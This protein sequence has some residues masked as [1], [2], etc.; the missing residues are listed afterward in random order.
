MAHQGA[1]SATE[2]KEKVVVMFGV[3]S[4]VAE[5]SRGKGNGITRVGRCTHGDGRK[6]AR[7]RLALGH[8]NRF[9]GQREY[10]TDLTPVNEININVAESHVIKA[11]EKQII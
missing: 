11:F 8:E 2:S 4:P 10:C 5:T 1:T 6:D 7:A 9:L 3:R